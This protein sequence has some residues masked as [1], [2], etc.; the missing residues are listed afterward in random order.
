MQ[1]AT[2]AKENAL[3]KLSKAAAEA[4]DAKEQEEATQLQAQQRI[5]AA[6]AELKTLQ[7]KLQIYPCTR[8]HDQRAVPGIQDM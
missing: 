7:D 8:A 1:G 6:K 2:S 3:E 4:K 5:A